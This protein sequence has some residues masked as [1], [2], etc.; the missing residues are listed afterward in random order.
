MKVLPQVKRAAL[1]AADVLSSVDLKPF[2]KKHGIKDKLY[3]KRLVDRLRSTYSLQPAPRQGRPRVYTA[4]ELQA[5]QDELTRPSQPVHSTRQLVQRLKEGGELS[6]GTSVKG[7]K[8]ALKRHLAEQGLQLGYGTR[9]KRQPITRQLAADRLKW[10]REMQGELTDM[11]V[12]TWY[13]EDEKPHGLG[14]K[15]RCEWP[16][17]NLAHCMA[18][19]LSF[20]GLFVLTPQGVSPCTILHW[21]LP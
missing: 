2:L 18:A 4:D 13:F 7:F 17:H 8:P 19:S 15:S 10:C 5:A 21:G 20:C 6:A 16:V 11:K 3:S 1:F 12:K 9:S 14:G